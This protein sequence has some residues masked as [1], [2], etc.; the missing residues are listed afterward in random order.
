MTEFVLAYGFVSVSIAIACVSV[1]V[2][3]VRWAKV[4]F[5]VAAIA[6]TMALTALIT[7]L[8]LETIT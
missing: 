8:A 6:A 3:S 5:I 7:T 2:F 4:L 1:A